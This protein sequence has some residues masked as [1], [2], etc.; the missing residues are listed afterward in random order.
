MY[1]IKKLDTQSINKWKMLEKKKGLPSLYNMLKKQDPETAECISPKDSY[2]I[3]RALNLMEHE[4]KRISQIK[5]EFK[6]ERLPYPYM[7]V[8]LRISKEDLL[9]RVTQRTHKILR[10]GLIEEIESLLK[11]GLKN[12]PPL[13]SV[14]YK[15]GR[16]YLEGKIKKK[17]LTEKIISS[18]MALAKKQKTWFQRDQSIKWFDYN[19]KAL[20]V[21]KELFQ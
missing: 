18:T 11:R 6:E 9:K 3:L 5:K 14:G 20:E 17:E 7:K 13:N 15:E 16:L 2:R 12:W 8:A 4:G 21:Y 19:R 10:E 1:P